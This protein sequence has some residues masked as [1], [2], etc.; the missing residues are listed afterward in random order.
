ME[1]IRLKGCRAVWES[2]SR[3]AWGMVRREKRWRGCVCGRVREGAIGNGK[4]GIA[5]DM[6]KGRAINV[7]FI[8]EISLNL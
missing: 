1:E 2:E 3:V 8:D 6:G 7:K 4:K 5:K